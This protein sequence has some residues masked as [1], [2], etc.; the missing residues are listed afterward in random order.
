M[1]MKNITRLSLALIMFSLFS[2]SYLVASVSA[3]PGHETGD[4]M[5]EHD[6]IYKSTDRSVKGEESGEGRVIQKTDN[7]FQAS[8][9]ICRGAGF[10]YG[11][12]SETTKGC[13]EKYIR[14]SK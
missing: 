4:R 9:N 1:F 14:D 6:V 13:F 10:A 2:I 3:N 7:G 8:W 11:V 5:N 12:Y